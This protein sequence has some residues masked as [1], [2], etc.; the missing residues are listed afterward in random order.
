M[1]KFLKH[2]SYVIS[3]Q[4]LSSIGVNLDFVFS[5]ISHL[6]LCFICGEL[7]HLDRKEIE[8]RDGVWMSPVIKPYNTPWISSLVSCHDAVL[9]KSPERERVPD[10]CGEVGQWTASYRS[11]TETNP[12][13]LSRKGVILNAFLREMLNWN[14]NFSITG[15]SPTL[16]GMV[17]L[18]L[19]HLLPTLIH[20]SSEC[21]SQ[22]DERRRVKAAPFIQVLLN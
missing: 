17:G 19:N 1:L 8:N 21:Y 10:V 20:K 11:P 14:P 6:F 4:C 22:G 13:F 18:V 2:H 3:A 15:T 7:W 9:E 12:L 5:K 16:C